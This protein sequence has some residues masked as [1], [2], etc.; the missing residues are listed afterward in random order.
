MRCWHVLKDAGK[1]PGRTDDKLHEVL[2][3]ALATPAPAA[4]QPAELT[5]EQITAAWKAWPELSITSASKSISFLR[6]VEKFKAQ[7]GSQ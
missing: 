7:G 4:Q 5:D 1:H 2:R 6:F 3:S